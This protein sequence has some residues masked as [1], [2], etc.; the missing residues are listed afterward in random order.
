[1]LQIRTLVVPSVKSGSKRQRLSPAA[2]AAA[3]VA[4]SYSVP[5]VPLETTVQTGAA[6]EEVAE[7]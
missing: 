7:E 2:I 5:K 4:P 6:S 3:V 1:M